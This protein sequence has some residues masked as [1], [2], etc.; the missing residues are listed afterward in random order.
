MCAFNISSL[1]TETWS[2]VIISCRLGDIMDLV[3]VLVIVFLVFGGG[4]Y[5][6]YRR[7]R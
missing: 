3:L 7:W 6:G 2:E 4:G 5:W 1:S